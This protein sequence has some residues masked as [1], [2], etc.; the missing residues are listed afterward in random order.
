M[1]HPNSMVVEVLIIERPGS[2]RIAVEEMHEV[3]GRSMK[4]TTISPNQMMKNRSM[5]TREMKDSRDMGMLKGQKPGDRKTKGRRGDMLEVRYTDK[6]F[7]AIESIRE[8]HAL[9]LGTENYEGEEEVAIRS[10]LTRHT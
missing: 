8:L 2:I 6:Q 3:L 1:D 9:A 5:R 10:A 4:M 7:M